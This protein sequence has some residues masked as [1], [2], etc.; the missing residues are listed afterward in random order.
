MKFI[1]RPLYAA[2]AASALYLSAS[3]A[4][5]STVDLTTGA[6]STATINGA[7]YAF[8]TSLGGTGVIQSFLRI[9]ANGTEQGYNTTVTKNSLL[10]F[11]E[12]FGSFTRN[13]QL[14][15]I[16]VITLA[17]V[18]HFQFI[19]DVNESSGS[20]NAFISLDQ[21]QIYTSPIASQNTTNLAS[22]GTLRYDMDAGADSHVR[23][24][25]RL[26]HGSGTTDMSLYVPTSFFTGAAPT[27]YLY[28][29]SLFGAQGNIAGRNYATSAG[30]EEWAVHTTTD[31]VYIP[32]PATLSL[33]FLASLFATRSR[34]RHEPPLNLFSHT[35]HSRL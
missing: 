33:F 30:F 12:K 8:G 22:L 16:P 3:T 31:S 14:N 13:I 6:G 25:S 21:I 5:A 26:S 28:F 29:Y 23:L 32:E 15:Q 9:Q 10:P 24:D 4:T 18:P 35:T 2:V 17:N 27:D 20:E 1:S 11:D 7:T 34:S 19:L